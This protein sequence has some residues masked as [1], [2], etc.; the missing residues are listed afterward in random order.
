MVRKNVCDILW[1]ASLIELLKESSKQKAAKLQWRPME[2]N[3]SPVPIHR[4]IDP[5]IHIFI[6]REQVYHPFCGLMFLPLTLHSILTT[7]FIIPSK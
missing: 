7:L 2:S 4:S 3:G 5:S 6:S 1:F